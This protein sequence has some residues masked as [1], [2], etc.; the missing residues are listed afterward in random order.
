MVR[1]DDSLPLPH[2][3]PQTHRGHAGGEDRHPYND[4]TPGAI[5]LSPRQAVKLGAADTLFFGRYFMPRAIRMASP[6][7]HREIVDK[8][9]NPANRLVAI[10]VYRDG[11]KTT[12]IR[13]I[14]AKRVAYGISFTILVVSASQ[15]HSKKTIRWLK[16][17]VEHNHLFK[18]TF[19]LE[20][21]SKWTDEEIEIYN[22]TLDQRIT[23]IALGI[24]GQVRGVNVEDY[25]PDFII[26]DDPCDEENTGT[27]E[28][29]LKLDQLFYGGLMRGLA[30]AT[31]NPTATLALLQTP[32]HRDDL[33][34]SACRDSAW[35]HANFGCFDENGNSRWPE[36]KPTEELLREKQSY[37]E[38]NQLSIWYREMEVKV[39]AE[40]TSA[41][42]GDWLQYWDVP[43]E[44]GI[45]YLAVDPTPPPKNTEQNTSNISTL[46]DAAIVAIRFTKGRVYLLDYYITKSPNPEEF[47][48]KIFEFCIL[49]K[50]LAIG[51][52]SIL[53]ARVMKYYLEREMM[54]RQH[55]I[56]I[57]PI[58]DKRKKKDRILQALTGRA[59][60]RTLYIHPSHTEFIDQFTSY[61][62]VSH[63]DLL[64][65]LSIAIEMINPALDTPHGN[66][67]EGEFRRLDEAAGELTFDEMCP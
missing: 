43:P 25:R 64:D 29:R 47:L 17:Q 35:V 52:E 6:K 66:L 21:G 23:V 13:V 36:R 19:G 62:D 7:F 15:D 24:H 20:R 61:P 14:I 34:E 30:P 54:K 45:T 46:D 63:D 48:A 50:P 1:P 16:T 2:N 39:V 37:A 60:Q 8:I 42:R 22:R 55:F 5:E 58:E 10:K 57:I 33:V 53:F 28:Q 49:Y 27:P 67:I 26:A 59:S 51:F 11:A 41:F 65:A 4:P 12:L 56:Q 38:R 44:E 3:P 9:E 18:E 40:E 31:E 32:L